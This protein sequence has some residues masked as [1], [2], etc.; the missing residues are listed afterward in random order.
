MKTD[1]ELKKLVNDE[2]E[3]D[4]RVVAQNIGV[5]VH[6]AIVTLSGHVST[7]SE[8]IAAE[9]AAERVS[10]VKGVVVKLEVRQSASQGDEA[11]VLA[12]RN[13]L[14]WYVHVPADDLKVEI[15]KGWITLRGTVQWGFQRRAAE[16]AVSH[17]RGVVGVSNLIRVEPKVVPEAIEGKIEAALRRHVEREARHI[18]IKAK[19]GIVTLEGNVDSFAERRAVAGAAWSAP[20]VSEVI[21]NLRIR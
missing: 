20:G 12:A 18:S 11:V 7:Y 5:E 9:A 4:P 14:Q 1:M 2:L 19:G 8:K 3:W 13:A 15:E 16:N 6:Q 21:N 17:I 10:G